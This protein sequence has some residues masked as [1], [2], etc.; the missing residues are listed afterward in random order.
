MNQAR[1]SNFKTHVE[2]LNPTSRTDLSNKT[3]RSILYW[4]LLFKPF[5]YKSFGWCNAHSVQADA[6]W[7]R[8]FKFQMKN[9]PQNQYFPAN[10]E[11]MDVH[12][13]ESGCIGK[14]IPLGPRDFPRAWILHPETRGISRG[15]SPREI[16][17]VEGC[18]THGQG[19]SR[20]RRGWISQSI[21]SLGG[22]RT[23]SH[24]YQGRIDFNTDNLIPKHMRK[25]KIGLLEQ[26][27]AQNPYD[28]FFWVTLY[29][30]VN[31]YWHFRATFSAW[32]QIYQ[33][34]EGSF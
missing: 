19:K 32:F 25:S 3:L 24:H 1:K 9:T 14:Y 4:K 30:M 20:G 27:W 21:P 29:F 34:W 11:R 18:K 8:S 13:L 2:K 6:L 31:Y 16:P 15:R 12:C 28:T 26:I 33:Y 22:A 10:A 5:P 17:R 7:G 23:F